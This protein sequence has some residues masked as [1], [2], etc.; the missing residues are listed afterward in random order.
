MDC[1]RNVIIGDYA[2]FLKQYVQ[3]F[4]KLPV[5]LKTKHMNKT[6]RRELIKKSNY[7]PHLQVCK[8]IF[9]DDAILSDI[10]KAMKPMLEEAAK[11]LLSPR[12]EAVAQLLRMADSI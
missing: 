10:V 5:Y 4:Q 12:P 3:Y 9:K 11:D 8:D 7:R 6:I 2:N 1:L